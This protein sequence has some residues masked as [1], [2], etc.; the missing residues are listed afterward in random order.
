MQEQPNPYELMAA[1]YTPTG[2]DELAKKY[3]HLKDQIYGTS[4]KTK[5]TKARKK[6]K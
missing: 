2:K 5:K 4:K 1:A 3:P 6:K